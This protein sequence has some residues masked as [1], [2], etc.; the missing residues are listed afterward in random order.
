MRHGQNPLKQQGSKIKRPEAITVGVLNF[1]PNQSG[2]HRHSLEVLKLC[3]ASIRANSDQPY[4]LLVIDNGSHE[5][6]KSYLC[7]EHEAGRIDYLILNRRNIGKPNG[8]LQVL[9][10]A[11]GNYVFYSDGDVYHGPG[12]MSGQLQVFNTFPNVGIVAG[13]PVRSLR[14]FHTNSTFSWLK[15][16]P[17]DV[18][19]EQ[20]DFISDEWT[21]DFSKSLGLEKIPQKWDGIEDCRVTYGGVRAYVGATH[22]QF[23]TAKNVINKLPHRR[24]EDAMGQAV[25]SVFD[26]PIDKAGLIRLSV[27][28]PLV[29]HIGNRIAED[30]LIQEC[31]RLVGETSQSK[32]HK[33]KKPAGLKKR[34]VKRIAKRI[35]EWSFD[36]YYS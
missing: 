14:E 9:H 23:L 10:S 2:Y 4:D 18:E 5:E 8:L 16:N 27:D 3:L 20:G 32:T 24:V 26:E 28:R 36:V 12:W 6:V 30:W 1:I 25:A 19:V 34:I 17:K 13:V 21:L 33:N 11:P 7:E 31:I 22:F 35:Y 29:Y 15:S